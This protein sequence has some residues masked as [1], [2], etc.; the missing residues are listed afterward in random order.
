MSF[1]AFSW[2]E[3]A[4]LCQFGFGPA[5]SKLPLKIELQKMTKRKPPD[6]SGGFTKPNRCYNQVML[7]VALAVLLAVVNRIARQRWGEQQAYM[8][9]RDQVAR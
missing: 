5:A 9:D 1:E 3:S 6:A 7:A 2:E 4:V 8:G